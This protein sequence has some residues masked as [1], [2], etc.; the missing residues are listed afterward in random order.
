MRQEAEVLNNPT[1][2]KENEDAGGSSLK[3]FLATPIK[4][5]IEEGNQFNKMAEIA[6]KTILYSMRNVGK[7]DVFCAIERECWGTNLLPGEKCTV[8]DYHGM[9]ESD[10]VL[11]F[12]CH[13]YGVHMELGWASSLKKPVIV[14]ISEKIGIKTSLVEGLST[15]TR[16]KLITYQSEHFIPGPRSWETL[17]PEICRTIQTMVAAA[18]LPENAD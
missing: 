4:F 12:P 13:S 7:F 18:R 1:R 16:T 6:L 9:V 11:A 10:I 8:F 3:V 15:L 17:F 14:C 5:L 2:K